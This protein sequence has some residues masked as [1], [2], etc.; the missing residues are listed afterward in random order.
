MRVEVAKDYRSYGKVG[1]YDFRAR[2]I[3]TKHGKS[4][5]KNKLGVLNEVGNL[6]FDPKG[7]TLIVFG[8]MFPTPTALWVSRFLVFFFKAKRFIHTR[9]EKLLKI[10]IRQLCLSNFFSL[11]I[12]D[13]RYS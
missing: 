12:S 10:E 5:L 4:S 8:D 6:F 11:L 1:R 3:I 7:S 9:F 2:V 13:I